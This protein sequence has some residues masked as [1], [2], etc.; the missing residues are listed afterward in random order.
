V[1]FG[2]V[3][4]EIWNKK[5]SNDF[6]TIKGVLEAIFAEFKLSNRIVFNEITKEEALEFYTQRKAQKFSF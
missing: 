6:F 2:S 4:N 3:N 5:I 1:H